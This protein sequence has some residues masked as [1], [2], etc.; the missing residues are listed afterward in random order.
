[1]AIVFTLFLM[2]GVTLFLVHKTTLSAVR[3]EPTKAVTSFWVNIKPTRPTISTS[4]AHQEVFRVSQ[5]HKKAA[6]HRTA[7]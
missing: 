7:W 3:I 6:A 2:H 5:D 1:M 4:K